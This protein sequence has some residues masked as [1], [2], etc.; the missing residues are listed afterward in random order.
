MHSVGSS[1]PRKANHQY[2]V[3]ANEYPEDARALWIKFKG[4]EWI[5]MHHTDH[6]T[7]FPGDSRKV[8]KN[9]LQNLFNYLKSEGFISDDDK[10][11]QEPTP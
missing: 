4:R 3:T 5:V 10:P 1:N 8:T 11:T 9:Q 2:P 6:F 7:A